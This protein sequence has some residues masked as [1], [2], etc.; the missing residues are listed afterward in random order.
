MLD[1]HYELRYPSDRVS[2]S[3]KE[4]HNRLTQQSK[5][6]IERYIRLTMPIVNWSKATMKDI[7]EMCG[8][9][10]KDLNAMFSIFYTDVDS[11]IV[12]GRVGSVYPKQEYTLTP[13]N[14]W[15]TFN[16]MDDKS[17]NRI[18]FIIKPVG[19]TNIKD[20]FNRR[21]GFEFVTPEPLMAFPESEPST[22]LDGDLELMECDEDITA[23][24][25]ISTDEPKEIINPYK[26]YLRA[27]DGIN[28]YGSK[29]LI[30]YEFD[31]P[32]APIK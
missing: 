32:L 2:D 28:L 12:G 30:D 22:L 24:K 5:Q 17:Y 31:A 13:S 1:I 6:L 27:N 20:F 4:A 16:L 14:T 11:T 23:D 15:D 18:K 3:L 10:T 19:P 9:V 29:P 26:K 8:H 25:L 7:C 21:R